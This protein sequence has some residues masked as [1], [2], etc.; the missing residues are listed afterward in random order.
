MILRREQKN[1]L[2]MCQISARCVACDGG[3]WSARMRVQDV[4]GSVKTYR[5]P[6]LY[7]SS[8]EAGLAYDYATL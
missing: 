7:G 1:R 6:F 4:D 2:R 3:K 5:V 8:S